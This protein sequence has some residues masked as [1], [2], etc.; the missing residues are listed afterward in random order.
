MGRRLVNVLTSR[1]V[2]GNQVM[3]KKID[4]AA[5]AAQHNA[6]ADKANKAKSHEAFLNALEG[7]G[8]LK[9]DSEAK[10]ASFRNILSTNLRAE[11]DGVSVE[12]LKVKRDDWSYL[13]FAAYMTSRIFPVTFDAVKTLAASGIK[14]TAWGAKLA[15]EGFNDLTLADTVG[16]RGLGSARKLISDIFADNELD[17]KTGAAKPKAEAK[18]KDDVAAGQGAAKEAA[19]PTVD[20]VK[21]TVKDAPKADLVTALA[22]LAED[23]L[24]TLFA[25]VAARMATAGCRIAN[26]HFFGAVCKAA[27]E[28]ARDLKS[29][30]TP[31]G[32]PVQASTN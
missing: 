30:A 4:P 14:Q 10:G 9:G 11:I 15:P 1:Q 13:Y 12:A 23:D 25:E 8:A 20:A 32:A 7:M 6:E 19:A 2:E 24:A 5:L 3:A 17:T 21:A 29:G 16:Y 26:D 22:T 27:G 31:C 18:P 28:R